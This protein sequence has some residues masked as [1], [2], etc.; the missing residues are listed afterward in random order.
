MVFS[1]TW[2]TAYEG[3]PPDSEQRSQGASRIRDF[4]RDVRERAEVDHSWAGDDDDGK[5]KQTSLV[6]LAAD[7]TFADGEIGIWNNGGVLKSRVGSEAAIN[8]ALGSEFASG[9]KMVFHQAAA[10]TGWTQDTS[11][12]DR[13]LRVVS[14]AGGA[15]AGGWTITGVTIPNHKHNAGTYE[16]TVTNNDSAEGGSG[17]AMVATQTNPVTGDSGNPTTLP[18]V[19]SDG[20]WRPAYTNVI[21]CTKS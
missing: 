8:V 10:P 13:M 18:S 16:V 14:G 7:P 19:V 15:N 3:L 6:D 1:S 2:N 11:L 9:T 20:S 17:D 21:I 12:N 4:K 5:H